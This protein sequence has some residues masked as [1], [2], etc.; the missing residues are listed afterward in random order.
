MHINP[1]PLFRHCDP[2]CPSYVVNT[3]DTRG[4]T[5]YDNLV[6]K[7]AGCRA[8]TGTLEVVRLKRD[9]Y[10]RELRFQSATYEKQNGKDRGKD[11]EPRNPDVCLLHGIPLLVFNS[12]WRRR[13]SFTWRPVLRVVAREKSRSIQNCE[14]A[15]MFGVWHR[16]A[17]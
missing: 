12:M 4:G 3:F 17:R 15:V 6:L 13:R 5:L 9:T 14:L 1:V 11:H 2:T 16:K 7:V 8:A 10:V